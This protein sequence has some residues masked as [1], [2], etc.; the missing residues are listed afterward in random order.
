MKRLLAEYL[1]T[2]ALVF[3]GTG[4]I[5][6]DTA[7]GGAVGNAGIALVF[8]LVV[9]AMILAFGGTS[10]AHLNPAVTWALVLAG[11][12]PWRDL[13]G[14]FGAQ[15]AGAF[16]ASGVLKL[17]SPHDPT[18]GATLPRIGPAQAFTVEVLL[19]ALLVHVI[20]SVP[21]RNVLL[22]AVA[23]G[24]TVGLEALFAGP[25][26]GASMNP[27][28]S[29]APAVIGGHFENLWLYPLATFLGASLAVLLCRRVCGGTCCRPQLAS[30]FPS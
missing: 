6:A 3:A 20:L 9:M 24:T 11:R 1:G 5:I 30:Q 23:I 21:G 13:P 10:G 8:G 7:S 2:F 17:L 15:L 27:A 14:Y 22:P 28:R 16:T 12:F 25:F 4:A 29:L 18:L 26:T 19:T